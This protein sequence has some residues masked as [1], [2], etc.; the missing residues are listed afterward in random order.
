MGHTVRDKNKLLGRVR[1]VKGQV[2]A[3]ERAL[4]REAGCDEVLRLIAASRGAMNALMAQVLEGHL[5]EH[6]VPAPG[7]HSDAAAVVDELI[8]VVRAYLK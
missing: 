6:V 8:D 4:E 1:R 7:L 5:R 3:V 2:A